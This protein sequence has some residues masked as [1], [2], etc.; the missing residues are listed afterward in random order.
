MIHAKSPG[1]VQD[2]TDEGSR[3]RR[4]LF[5]AQ[6]P[7]KSTSMIHIISSCNIIN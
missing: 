4:K 2:L 5:R 1:L 7:L 3:S 6:F